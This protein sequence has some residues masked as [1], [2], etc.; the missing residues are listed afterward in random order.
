MNRRHHDQYIEQHVVYHSSTLVRIHKLQLHR[1]YLILSVE[2][3]TMEGTECIFLIRRHC[4][5]THIY[6]LIPLDPFNADRVRDINNGLAV[7]YVGRVM[8]VAFSIQ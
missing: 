1:R 6:T 5:L 4:P 2:R 8:G 7:A 3:L